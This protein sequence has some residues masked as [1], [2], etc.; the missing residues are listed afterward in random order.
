MM[1]GY[2]DPNDKETHIMDAL[3]ATAGRDK[4]ATKPHSNRFDRQGREWDEW[5]I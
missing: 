1:C 2:S 3:A 4:R 5:D